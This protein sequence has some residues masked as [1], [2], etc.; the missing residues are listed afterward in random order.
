VTVNL[1]NTSGEALYLG[2]TAGR[3]VESGEV[4]HVEGDLAKKADQ[5]E[6]AYV[7]VSGDQ[8]VAYPKSVWTAAGGS[9]SATPDVPA[10]G[11]VDGEGK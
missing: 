5:V 3:R 2:G 9:T 10:P 8:L 6:D 7:V 11:S 4:V 1:K